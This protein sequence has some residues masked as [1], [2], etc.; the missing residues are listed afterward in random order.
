MRLP[1]YAS[2]FIGRHLLPNWREMYY[3][4][5]GVTAGVDAATVLGSSIESSNI[6]FARFELQA[7]DATSTGP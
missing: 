5:A 4:R 7:F 1:E 6:L 3:K 2:D